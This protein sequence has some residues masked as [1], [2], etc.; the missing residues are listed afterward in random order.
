LNV[1]VQAIEKA[2]SLDTAKVREI[3]LKNKFLTFVSDFMFDEN[4]Q[5]IEFS[6]FAV[7]QYSD[8]MKLVTFDKELIENGKLVFPAPTWE[9]RDCIHTSNCT[10][11]C[12][13][14]SI[15]SGACLCSVRIKVH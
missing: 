3:L 7:Q 9:A 11:S 2:G 12:G 5:S 14:C 13:T 1:L 8:S 4:G 6:P 15:F 10:E